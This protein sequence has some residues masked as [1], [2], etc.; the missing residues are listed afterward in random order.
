[1]LRNVY[2]QESLNLCGCI[3]LVIM[4]RNSLDHSKYN[5]E[6]MQQFWDVHYSFINH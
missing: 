6:F 2:N 4:F 3:V 1:M 5:N